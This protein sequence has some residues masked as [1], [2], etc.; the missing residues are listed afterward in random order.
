M[1]EAH[2]GDGTM[3][4]SAPGV[5]SRERKNVKEAD[6]P[7]ALPGRISR[8][9]DRQNAGGERWRARGHEDRLPG[10]VVIFF[11]APDS[12]RVIIF[13]HLQALCEFYSWQSSG[14]PGNILHDNTHGIP[15]K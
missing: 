13:F 3:L 2:G 8:A 10:T 7:H 6:D 12:G 5:H 1:R 15:D 14:N 9:E 4:K 11:S